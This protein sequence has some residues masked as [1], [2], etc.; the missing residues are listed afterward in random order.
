ME[1]YLIVAFVYVFFTFVLSKLTDV[2]DEK[3]RIPGFAPEKIR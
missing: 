2:L 1:T 3:L